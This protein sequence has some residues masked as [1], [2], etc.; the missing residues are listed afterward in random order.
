MR[1]IFA[2]FYIKRQNNNHLNQT[3][4]LKYCNENDIKYNKYVLVLKLIE[5]KQ[6]KM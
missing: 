1:L 3:N 5:R 6:K 4:C 2:K